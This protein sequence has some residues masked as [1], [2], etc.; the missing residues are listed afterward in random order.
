MPQCPCHLHPPS[1]VSY[2]PI[3][4]IHLLA[5]SIPRSTSPTLSPLSS[6]SFPRPLSPTLPPPSSVSL[7]P[8]S[9]VLRLLPPHLHPLSFVSYPPTS[10]L[11]LLATSI[12]RPTECQGRA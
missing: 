11:H 12:P 2:P 7:P 5:T 6:I 8:P 10:I 4:M 1:S 3:S 9:P